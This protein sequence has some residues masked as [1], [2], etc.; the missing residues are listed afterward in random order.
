MVEGQERAMTQRVKG[1]R[2]LVTLA[3]LTNACTF[4]LVP[5]PRPGCV[6]AMVVR[7]TDGDTIEV[8]VDGQSYK[9][10]YIGIDAPETRHPDKGVEPLGPEAAAKNE[11]LVANRLVELEKDVS[12]TDRYGRLLRYVWIGDMMVN[13]ELVRLG[14]AQVSTYPPDVKYQEMFLQLQ[15]EARQECRGLWGIQ[16]T[17]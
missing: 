6:A 17:E 11:E 1:M 9:L 2:L 12:E 4:S 15:R 8:R 10:R 14:Y 7:V 13:A 16:A 5:T 3:V